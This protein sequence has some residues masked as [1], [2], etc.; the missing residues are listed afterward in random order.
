M[1]DIKIRISTAVICI[2]VHKK[3]KACLLQIDNNKSSAFDL[4]CLHSQQCQADGD[5][6]GVRHGWIHVAR[7]DSGGTDPDVQGNHLEVRLLQ[8]Y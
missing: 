7:E 4:C 2:K 8:K 5:A 3:N 6:R 1:T